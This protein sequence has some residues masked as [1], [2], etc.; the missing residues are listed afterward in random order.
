M[1]LASLITYLV[2]GWTGLETSL[3]AIARILH[4]ST[5]T[6][7]EEDDTRQAIHTPQDWPSQGTI[8]YKNLTAS[9][10]PMSDPVLRDVSLEIQS[11]EHIAICGRTG[12]GKS[13]LV[14]TLFGLLHETCGYIQIDER[15][16]TA[17]SLEDLRAGIV[18]LPQEPFLINEWTVRQNLGFQAMSTDESYPP[19]EILLAALDEVGLVANLTGLAGHTLALLDTPMKDIESSLSQ[20]EKQLFCLARATLSKRRIVVLDEATSR[21]VASRTSCFC[22]FRC[23]KLTS[24]A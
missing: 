17:V 6:P 7:M 15:R 11:G 9:Y 3:S 12:S 19:D 10:N 18:A 24:R 5:E 1:D 4:F 8:S 21:Y 20:G 16:T 2:L 14:A 23:L 13:S 22:H